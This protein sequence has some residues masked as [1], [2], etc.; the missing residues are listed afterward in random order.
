MDIDQGIAALDMAMV[1]AP[2]D[3]LDLFVDL[4]L[5]LDSDVDQKFRIPSIY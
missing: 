3:M 4:Q 1:I 2:M 5:V